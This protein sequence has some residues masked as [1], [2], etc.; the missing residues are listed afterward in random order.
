VDRLIGDDDVIDLGDC[1]I[2]VI[3]TPGH[4]PGS[5]SFLIAPDGVLC[6]GD[7][8][9]LPGEAPIYDDALAS[10]ASMQRLAALRGVRWLCSAWDDPCKGA[11]VH[12]RMEAGLRYLR[13]IH[14]LVR[15]SVEAGET[16]PAAIAGTVLTAAGVKGSVNPLVVRTIIATMR[17]AGRTRL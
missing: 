6:S 7:A 8:V 10:T 3:A 12:D 13:Q 2:E 14:D 16:D 4:S 15:S 11:A 5:V 17:T 1:R 9:P